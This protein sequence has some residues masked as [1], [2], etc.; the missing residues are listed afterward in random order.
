M[1]CVYARRV[2]NLRLQFLFFGIDHRHH[3]VRS[4][5]A[6]EKRKY[7]SLAFVVNV[8]PLCWESLS[9]R[10]SNAQNKWLRWRRRQCLFTSTFCIINIYVRF[11]NKNSKNHEHGSHLCACVL[12]AICHQYNAFYSGRIFSIQ[13][14][15]I[16]RNAF[17]RC[18]IFSP[19]F[20]SII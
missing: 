7:I 4:A 15:I 14:Q 13:S 12:G 16:Q 9:W 18:Q 1:H 20:Y 2:L 5:I 11:I 8:V 17:L 19:A 10:S 3:A 6:R